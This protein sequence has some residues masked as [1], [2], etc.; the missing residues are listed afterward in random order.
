MNIPLLTEKDIDCRVQ[1]IFKN[2][3][4]VSAILLLYKDARVD[5]R[6]LDK[7]YGPMNWRRT[8]EVIN[9]NLFCNIDIWD[10]TKKE[11]VR[12][13][14]VGT[15][16]NTEK[17][18]GQASDSFKRA[19]TNVG[20]GRELYTAPFIVVR[21]NEDE[22][23]TKDL[24][25]K[26][27]LRCKPTTKFY[28]SKIEYDDDK[29]I[30]LLKICDKSGNERFYYPKAKKTDEQQY[31]SHQQTKP[32]PKDAPIDQTYIN[33]IRTELKRTG[34]DENEML[35]YVSGRLGSLVERIEDIPFDEAKRIL[36]ILEK[37]NSKVNA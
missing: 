15:E 37:R 36:Q 17:E 13:Q 16:S 19:G 24:G 4:G 21:L 27:V 31:D 23:D 30:S 3:K 20:I 26:E 1:S 18:K 11:W 14:D 8:H 12:K 22:Y 28:V 2:S 9:G 34:W 35:L 29:T 10:E 6:I 25:G 5:M 7:V 33:T 32:I